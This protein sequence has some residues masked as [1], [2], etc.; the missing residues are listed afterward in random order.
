M[1]LLRFFFQK[2][3]NVIHRSVTSII[4]VTPL[5]FSIVF[6][7]DLFFNGYFFLP[8]SCGELG[9]S[10]HSSCLYWLMVLYLV[11][12]CLAEYR[13]FQYLLYKTGNQLIVAECPY[14]IS[15]FLNVLYFWGIGF[16]LNLLLMHFYHLTFQI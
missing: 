8:I 1:F 15:T 12:M 10:F 13:V 5:C 2:V 4:S 7:C 16:L 14:W 9:K 6:G 3:I 11:L